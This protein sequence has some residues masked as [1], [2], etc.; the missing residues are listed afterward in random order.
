M[1]VLVLAA[2]RSTRIRSDLTKMLHEVGKTKILKRVL[3]NLERADLRNIYLVLGHQRELILKELP[4]YRYVIQEEQLG[5]GHAV[6]AARG[7]D[8][9]HTLVVFGDKPLFKPSTLRE[10]A[11]FHVECGANITISTIEHPLPESYAEGYGT[12]VRHDGRVLALKKIGSTLE[13]DGALYAFRT[14]WLWNYINALWVRENGEYFLP[15]LVEIAT[16]R[17]EIVQEYRISNYHEAIGI[18]TPKQL[19][20]AEKYLEEKLV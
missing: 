10:F 15:D 14:R 19:A 6:M 12:V 13:C 9:E 17:G 5:T 3:S 11:D 1:Q 2:G 18:N 7:L 8:A 20:E 4:K 16:K